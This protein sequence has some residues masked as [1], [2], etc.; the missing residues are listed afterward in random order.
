MSKRAGGPLLLG[1]CLDD[2]SSQNLSQQLYTGLRDQILA[3][4]LESGQRIPS[5]RVLAKDL[6]ISRTITVNV[7]ER[8]TAEGLLEA[9]IGSGTFVAKHA[10]FTQST[11]SEKSSESNKN[12]ASKIELSQSFAKASKQAITQHLPSTTGPF[13]TGLP[14]DD[15]FPVDVW[16][17]R[18]FRQYNSRSE[19]MMGYPDPLGYGPL[20]EAI[21]QHMGTN[22]GINCAYED[23][24]VVGGAQEAFRLI[25]SVL[26][27]KSDKVWFENP[28]A[29]GARNS[30]IASEAD[31]VP[32]PVD[33][34][35]LDV[36]A[37]LKKSKKFKL[38][39]VT[40]AHQQ[41]MGVSM[42]LERRLNLLEAAAKTNGFVLEDDYDGEFRY[43]GHPLP[44]LKSI[45]QAQRV[46]Y[47]GS[48]SKTLMPAL[49][50]GFLI[51]PPFLREI[52]SKAI[53]I[54]T[55]GVPPNTQQFLA[56]AIEDGF[57]SAHIRRMRKIYSERR[58]ILFNA[59]K[60]ELGGLLRVDW[61]PS[62][63]HTI[64]HLLFPAD[65]H[66]TAVEI[67]KRGIT[68]TPIKRFSIAPTPYHGLV[69]GFSSARPSELKRGVQILATELERLK[70]NAPEQK[71][72]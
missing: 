72:N 5:T 60:S 2:D 59:A 34:Y 64:G 65:E 30:L 8:L 24:F 3:G 37:G 19:I 46:I 42:S 43:D 10:S 62:G 63:L 48:F 66:R 71:D 51:T 18:L 14:A 57:F 11:A 67:G 17:R 54:Y 50:I 53:R 16:R 52:F 69:M 40:P 9:R 26:L 29:I 44:A 13:T 20:R 27:N 36:E 41:P 32:V 56:T 12:L 61:T 68:V 25:F 23:I 58:T 15:V 38:A 39:F 33:K 45:D 31:I 7:V 21:R 47:V 49:R 22:R 4:V 28:G 70:N 6:Q 55:Q 1:L 35:G